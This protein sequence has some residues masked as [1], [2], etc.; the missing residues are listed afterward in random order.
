M[1]RS[2]YKDEGY[3][4]TNLDTIS[5]MSGGPL[6]DIKSGALIG[7]LNG[8]LGG[9]EGIGAVAY[10]P[11]G[12]FSAVYQKRLDLLAKEYRVET[13]AC[14][15]QIDVFQEEAAG[16]ESKIFGGDYIRCLPP[17]DTL[18]ECKRANG[19][20]RRATIAKD[21]KSVVAK[22]RDCNNVIVGSTSC[23]FFAGS[24]V[25]VIDKAGKS[26]IV[27]IP[28]ELGEYWFEFKKEE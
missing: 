1:G 2:Y 14:H 13:P 17:K 21:N 6:I 20:L 24:K 7:V 27:S 23:S 11:D 4:L 25:R 3:Y 19:D 5:G 9:I 12:V 26:S 22:L 18:N 28:V 8:G 16:K 10:Y 15:C